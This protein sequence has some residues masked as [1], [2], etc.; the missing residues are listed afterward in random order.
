[1]NSLVT[2]DNTQLSTPLGTYASE[3]SE[4]TTA[5][6]VLQS[7][8]AIPHLTEA[9]SMYAKASMSENTRRAYRA[10]LADF[11]CWGGCIPASSEMVAQYLADRAQVLSPHTLAR[12]L[13]ALAQA[14]QLQLLPNPCCAE[15]VRRTMRGIRRVKGVAQRR[16]EPLLREDLLSIVQA[17]PESL[18]GRR[19]RALLMVGF[20]GAFRRS[21]LVAMCVADVRFVKEGMTILL[22]RSKTDQEGQ[23]RV[24]AIPFARSV[25]CPVKSL[26]D[27]LTS[28]QIAR[29]LLFRR[30]DSRGRIGDRS[31]SGSGIALVIK[32]YVALAGLDPSRFSGH[33]L[34]AGLVTSA[35]QSGVSGWKIR[36]QTGH[37]SDAMVQR[38]IRDADLFKDNASGKLL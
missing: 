36:Q 14:H 25:L 31:I 24:V 28:A 9:V 15:I 2:F 19:N 13:V 22:P 38:Y 34:R 27:W 10:D 20:A 1:M 12:R 6:L 26:R 5:R 16:V 4:G 18:H 23:G 11:L 29:G 17:I 30:I 3:K 35:A 33:S 37:K 7:S 8:A 32:K 21:E